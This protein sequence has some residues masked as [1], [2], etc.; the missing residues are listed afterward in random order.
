MG[1]LPSLPPGLATL[2][3]YRNQLTAVPP[4]LLSEPL[5]RC[6]LASNLVT[7]SQLARQVGAELAGRYRRMQGALRVWRGA[8]E[9]G[10]CLRGD[11]F[12]GRLPFPTS[13]PP[14]DEATDGMKAQDSMDCLQP[15]YHDGLYDLWAE[16]GAA[17]P[18]P[19]DT[20]ESGPGEPED[21]E[22]QD[23]ETAVPCQRLYNLARMDL[24]QF[25]GAGQFCPADLHTEPAIPRLEGRLQVQAGG[26]LLT[27][28]L[29]EGAA[30]P[31]GEEGELRGGEPGGIRPV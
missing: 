10:H 18:E 27:V 29:T 8:E 11:R 6:D 24:E 25:W 16:G 30:D 5:V 7:R 9:A 17:A 13:P 28:S 1:E 15:V 2:D 23:E 19:E 22:S 12:R 3:A 21:W 31:A 20:A 14:G 26:E 4:D